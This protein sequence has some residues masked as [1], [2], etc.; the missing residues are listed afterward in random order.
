MER[1]LTFIDV[2]ENRLELWLK[3]DRVQL[4]VIDSRP[5]LEAGELRRFASVRFAEYVGRDLAARLEAA[6][7]Q[8]REARSRGASRELIAALDG[9]LRAI[10][11]VAAAVA[12]PGPLPEPTPGLEADAGDAADDDDPDPAPPPIALPGLSDPPYPLLS[13]RKSTR[14]SRAKEGATTGWMWQGEGEG[15]GDGD[16]LVTW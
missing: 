16:E 3:Q 11:D 15:E 10:D 5:E 9:A 8:L 1:Q 6:R 7:T 13:G 12:V 4:V 14:G 2:D